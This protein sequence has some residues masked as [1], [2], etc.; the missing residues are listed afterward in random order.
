[1]TTGQTVFAALKKKSEILSVGVNAQMASCLLRFTLHCPIPAKFLHS[2]CKFVQRPI[3]TWPV[4]SVSS[5]NSRGLLFFG[6][7]RGRLFEGGNYF[8][9]CLVE[10][11]R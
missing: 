3:K 7:K 5:N 4:N 6:T 8:R 9:Y 10:F 2:P 1:M 11:V